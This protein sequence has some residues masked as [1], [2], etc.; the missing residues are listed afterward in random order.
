MIDISKLAD[1]QTRAIHSALLQ[2]GGAG[3]RDA[4]YECIRIT[5]MQTQKAC[6]NE[7]F[8]KKKKGKKK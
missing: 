7:W 1:E 3:M 5:L 6:R 4:V 2:Y 8:P